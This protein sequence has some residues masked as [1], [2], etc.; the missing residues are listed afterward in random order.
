MEVVL[1]QE[2]EYVA[3]VSWVGLL[4]KYSVRYTPFWMSLMGS[5]PSR[6]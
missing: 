4:L 5:N 6:A 1:L 3:T 2:G